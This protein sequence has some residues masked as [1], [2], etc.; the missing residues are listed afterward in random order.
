MKKVLLLALVLLWVLPASAQTGQQV[1]LTLAGVSGPLPTGTP[2]HP[3]TAAGE[4]LILTISNTATCSVQV[5]GDPP[6]YNLG[7][8]N[9]HDILVNQ[10]ASVNG[11]IGFPVTAVR[12]NCSAISSGS[13]TL[14]LVNF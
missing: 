8:W 2:G 9:N 1:T 12:L 4:S 13:V 3:M 11:N 14:S 5:T 10:T 7:N 6:P